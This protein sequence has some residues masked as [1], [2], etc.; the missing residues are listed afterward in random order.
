MNSTNFFRVFKRGLTSFHRNGWL[1]TATISVM[2]ITLFVVGSLYA[3]N[4]LFS[5]VSQE[6]QDKIDISAYFKEDAPEEKILETRKFVLQDPDVKS[7]EYVSKD[8][9]FQKFKENHKEDQIINDS[10]QELGIN[11]LFAS[12]NIKAASTDKFSDIASSLEDS[13]FMEYIREV[14]YKKNKTSI[15]NFYSIA[16]GVKKSG[17]FTALILSIIVILITFNTVRLTIYTHRQEIEIMKLV[18]GT[19]WFIRGPF[20]IEGILYGILACAAAMLILYGGIAI[21]SPKLTGFLPSSDLMNFYKTNFLNLLF[22]EL[23]AGIILGGLSSFIAIRKY[24]DQ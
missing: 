18:G 15:D 11:P 14:N 22:L 24:L 8:E 5:N 20:I 19:N 16:G 13:Q 12:L 17:L 4:D 9:A 10:L 2:A 6:L 21:L 7:V 23:A 3:A 1:S